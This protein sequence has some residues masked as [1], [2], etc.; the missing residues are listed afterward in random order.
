MMSLVLMILALAAPP[1]SVNRIWL[2]LEL[3]PG[4]WPVS[5]DSGHSVV[6]P[7][8]AH[9]LK[10]VLDSLGAHPVYFGCG[11]ALICEEFT[12]RAFGVDRQRESLAAKLRSLPFVDK[13][14]VGRPGYY[15]L[16][17]DGICPGTD[18]IESISTPPRIDSTICAGE[19]LVKLEIDSTGTV[20]AF[21]PCGELSPDCM[22]A[23]AA[24]ASP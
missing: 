15:A 17:W 13:A 19:I 7:V 20:E 3:R 14:A 12:P 10:E 8:K 21:E 11:G 16:A 1:D 18:G 5:A 2:R 23:V 22:R 4:G 24:W 6:W 9:A